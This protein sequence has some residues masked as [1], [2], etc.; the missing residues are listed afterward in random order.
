MLKPVIALC[1]IGLAGGVIA[2]IVHVQTTPFAFTN[3]PQPVSNGHR[4]P[5]Q[6]VIGAARP[7]EA[8]LTQ[9]AAQP[10]VFEPVAVEPDAVTLEEITVQAEPRQHRPRA[11]SGILQPRPE[12][13]ATTAPA[14]K[15]CS[16]W[17]DLGPNAGV[18]RL[19]PETQN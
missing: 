16:D 10:N 18:R 8:Q 17:Q 3:K 7:A 5:L 15:P 14:L 4:G 9:P 6:R 1:S 2:L 12:N 11:A 13:K 19:C